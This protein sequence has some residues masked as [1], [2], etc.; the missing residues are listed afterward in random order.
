MMRV[1]LECALIAEGDLGKT[2]GEAVGWVRLW[3]A[4]LGWNCRHGEGGR[5]CPD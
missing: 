4:R 1:G 5:N 2:A 3:L